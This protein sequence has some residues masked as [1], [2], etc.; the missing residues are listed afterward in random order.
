[1]TDKIRASDQRPRQRRPSREARRLAILE[2]ATDVLLEHG[3]EAGS[4]AEVAR[5]LGGS[6][7]TL[8]RHFESKQALFAAVVRAGAS[9]DGRRIF[10]GFTASGD[11]AFD[12]GRLGRA[13]LTAITAEDHLALH[14]AVIAEGGRSDL[15]KL[16][17]ELGHRAAWAPLAACLAEAMEQG[18]LRPSSPWT[19]AMHFRGLCLSDVYEMRLEGVIEAL[20]PD[21][22]ARAADDAVDVFLRAYSPLPAIGP[23]TRTAAR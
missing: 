12:L 20:T 5:R 9:L 14:R 10:D 18:R 7:E 1:M 6:K 11:L 17:F 15:G 23:I 22:I 21:E 13:L 8:Y 4:M 2:V 19:A 3:Y 16:Y